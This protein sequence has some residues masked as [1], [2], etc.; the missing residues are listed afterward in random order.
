MIYKAMVI[1]YLKYTIRNFKLML[2]KIK[3]VNIPPNYI[4]MC[5]CL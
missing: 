3:L 4:W 2:N 5:S 1:I